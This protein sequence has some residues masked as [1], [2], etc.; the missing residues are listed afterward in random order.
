MNAE[1]HRLRLGRVDLPGQTYLLTSNCHHRQPRFASSP[2]AR[3][4]MD[5]LLWL[6]RA[7]RLELVAL[8]VMPDHVHFVATLTESS[9]SGL[10]HSFKRHTARQVNLIQRA[11]GPVW[12]PGYHDH[13]L[14]A[15]EDLAAV[16]DYCLHNPVRA[17]LVE[18]FRA[19]E[20]AWC[21]AN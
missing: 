7:G 18:D 4:V 21:R 20:H 5:S 1:S 8:V 12:Q 16:V 14:R 3:V 19:Y 9:L 2:A 15:E 6:D 10:M 11:S 13:A 17:G